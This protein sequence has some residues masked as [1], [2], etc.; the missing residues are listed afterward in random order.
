MRNKDKTCK[1]YRG[2][3]CSRPVRA[4]GLC[5]S[6]YASRAQQRRKY[7]LSD[8][9]E[10]YLVERAAGHCELCGTASDLKTDHCHR[11]KLV[12][13]L[14]CHQCNVGLG[15]FK[16]DPE[17][18]RKAIDWITNNGPEGALPLETRI[19]KKASNR[20]SSKLLGVM[21]QEPQTTQ[22]LAT[23]L[24]GSDTRAARAKVR[25]YASEL[26]HQGKVA[27]VQKGIGYT[28]DLWALA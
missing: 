2:V 9:A 14:L 10:V 5:K 7:Q 12:R 1:G 23:T 20:V 4:S 15:M 21:T 25:R 18:M 16:D 24:F 19:K 26:V 22:Q 13:G 6:H 27:Q 28:P 8:E 11:S 3:S 17:L